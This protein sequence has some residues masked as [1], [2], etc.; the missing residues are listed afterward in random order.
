MRDPDCP[1]GKRPKCPECG[2]P[3]E[4]ANLYPGMSEI[5]RRAFRCRHCRNIQTMNIDDGPERPES[6]SVDA[7][8]AS[9]RKA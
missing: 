4:K 6:R 5:K 1:S 8:D 7:L 3:M 2:H 9:Q